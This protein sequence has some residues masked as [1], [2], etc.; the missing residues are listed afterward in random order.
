MIK[1]HSGVGRFKVALLDEKDNVMLA[2]KGIK[3][4]EEIKVKG[5]VIRIKDNIQAG[6][7]IAIERIK[8]GDKVIKMGHVIGVA[9]SDVEEGEHV[10]IHNLTSTHEIFKRD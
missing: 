2:L 9:T 10:H 1:L 7:K 5:K 8:K 6:H 3:K 4:G